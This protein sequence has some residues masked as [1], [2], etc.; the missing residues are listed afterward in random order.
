[1]VVVVVVVVVAK[2][3]N[4]LARFEVGFPL[5]QVGCNHPISRDYVR[6]GFEGLWLRRASGF[7]IPR[8]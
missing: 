2:K 6:T 7:G 8:S 3:Q 5:A 1:M 4:A